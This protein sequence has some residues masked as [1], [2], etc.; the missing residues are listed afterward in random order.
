MD[1][2]VSVLISVY[3]ARA[4]ELRQSIESILNQSFTDFEF[5]II[6]DGSTND[7]EDVILSY[8]DK[9]IKYV[10]NETNLKIISSLN[11]GLKL[12]NGKY[13]ARID[14][15]D[16]SDFTRLEKQ[17]E[18]MEKNLNVGALGTFFHRLHTGE[19]VTL[20][21]DI[22]D[23]KLLTRY[24]KSCI[25]NPS[26]MIRKSVLT[27]NNLQYDKNCIHAEDFKLWSDMSY[28]CDIAVLP[29]VLTF[30]RSH[31]DGVSKSNIE[32]QNKIVTVVL[33][34]NMIRDFD[35]DKKYLYS[36]LLK[37]VKCE[38]VS[39][40]EFWDFKAHADKVIEYVSSHTSNQYNVK[41]Y[42]YSMLRYF[43]IYKTQ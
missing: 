17:V 38:P 18:F 40:H 32:W 19:D 21:T 14:S 39:M 9:R 4:N 25:S 10:K 13:I 5:I 36:I 20:P 7:T 2:L 6:N 35:C 29:E 23:I 8:N 16:Y 31:K 42:I 26:S 22:N 11:K 1:A 33:W 24:V 15:D 27:E 30:I 34:D 12:C 3:N 37:Y 28:Y 41:D 43:L